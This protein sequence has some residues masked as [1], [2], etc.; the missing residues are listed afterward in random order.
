MLQSPPDVA[1]EELF[2]TS[3]FSFY[4]RDVSHSEIFHSTI[5]LSMMNKLVKPKLK[6]TFVYIFGIILT[7]LYTILSQIKLA[8]VALWRQTLLYETQ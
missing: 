7:I 4:S 5:P 8:E 2:F 3:S 1:L 6:D